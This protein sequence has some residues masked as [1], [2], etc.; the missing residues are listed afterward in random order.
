M[1]SLLLL[2]AGLSWGQQQNLVPRA[3][4]DF[5]GGYVD[6]VDPSN[7]KPNES[8][9]LLNVFVD[10]PVGSV[11]PRNG[12]T[13]CGTTPSGN[14]A[15]ALYSYNKADGTRRLLVSDNATVWS[16]PDC[17]N[18]IT[19]RSGLSSSDQ[20]Y[21][22]TVRDE[23]WM[24]NGTTWPSTWNGSTSTVL[25]GRANTPTTPTIPK[26]SFI[27]F[28]K[29]RVWCG[30]PVGEPSA[31]YFSALTDSNGNDLSPSTG[32]LSWPADNVFQIDENAG[33]RL[34]GI[35]AYKNRLYAFKDN[36]IW[37]VGFNNEFDNFVRKTFASVGSRFQTSIIERE[38]LLEFAGRDGLYAFDGDNSIRI[39]QK[40]ENKYAALN[41]PLVSQ[42]YKTWTQSSDFTVGQLSSATANATPGSVTLNTQPAALT[43]GNFE[44]GFL[45]PWHCT[46]NA[47]P[48]YCKIHQHGVDGITD[49][50][51]SGSA[52]IEGTYSA[53]L[54]STVAM[55]EYGLYIFDNAGS[56][57]TTLTYNN[58]DFAINA[59]TTK[60]IDTSGYSGTVVRLHFNLVNGLGAVVGDLYSGTFTARGQ[61]TFQYEVAAP[62]TG[63][64]GFR[65]L[66]NFQ[67][68]QYLSSGT[69]TSE[70]YN[71]VAVSTWGAFNATS[72]TN[73]GSVNY[74]IRYGVDDTAVGAMAF[75]AITPGSIIPA[76]TNQIKVQLRARLVAPTDLD[77]TPE[78][79]DVQISWNSGGNNTQKIYSWAWKNAL[80]LSASSGTATT[81]N[82]VIHKT[83]LPLDAFTLHDLKIGPMTTYNDNFYAGASSHSAIYRM[84]TGTNDN[85]AAISWF[86]ESKDENFGLPN[87]PKR[88]T[89]V[90]ADYRNNNSCNIRF[91][92]VRNQDTTYCVGNAPSATALGQGV[93]SRRLNFNSDPGYTFRFKVCDDQ[94]DQ[95]P[96]I[97][98]IGGWTVPTPRRGD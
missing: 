68:P 45:S 16:T 62:H 47:A 8:P 37:E 4:R 51:G 65:K 1:L 10:D 92:Y 50:N 87:N 61:L 28:W 98:G 64:G 67:S 6:N 56:T 7:L 2:V 58:G 91:G 32:S 80:W 17:T 53:V 36:G 33:S 60:T 83:K 79:Q 41:Q 19:V 69:W 78:L 82:I 94:L 96:T 86:W 77:A 43:N 57:R 76:A 25:D 48:I 97:I 84:D 15:T 3:F 74:E 39:S 85:G 34:Y 22:S 88:L 35:K 44:L 49:G 27:E 30:A 11:R 5:S 75:Q 46:V 81:N 12:F 24:V 71:T 40:I 23:V 90:N 70:I 63:S 93:G 18:W 54:Y 72:E 59:V 89:E 13:Q 95:A 9:A 21:F 52:A 42:N 26:C 31:I 20:I 38:G 55:N 73:G 29:E 14:P 66:D